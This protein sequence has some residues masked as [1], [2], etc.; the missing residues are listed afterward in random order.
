LEAI[1]KRYAQD[2][3]VTIQY[4]EVKSAQTLRNLHPECEVFIGA[5]GAHSLIRREIFGD[6]YSILKD[7]HHVV[8]LK[9]EVAGS[10]RSLDILTEHYRSI[11]LMPSSVFEYVGRER[12]SLTPI[13]LRFFVAKDVYD[14]IGD[15]SFKDPV[16][17]ENYQ[18]RLPPTLSE[19]INLY[20]TIRKELLGDDPMFSTM[21]LGKLTLSVY[22]SAS[23]SRSSN[24]ANWYLVGDAAMGV[25]F[26]RSLN[27]GLL[28]GSRLAQLLSHSSEAV[29][30]YNSYAS[31][32]LFI[33][34]ARARIKSAGVHLHAAFV[35]ASSVVPWQVNKWRR[36]E[37]EHYM[38]QLYEDE[39]SA[40]FDTPPGTAFL[41]KHP[42][43]D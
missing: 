6:E 9:Y 42:S 14:R 3:S 38:Q 2:L 28:C 33:E 40:E 21:K 37:V 18:Q 17:I 19:S 32:R 7:L 22:G 36:K 24:R 27:A 12:D 23:F 13:T 39:A 11:K 10:T 25:P 4:T 8:E 34:Q 15:V 20:L 31:R 41:K 16:T 5:D 43:S 26:F 30:D 29:R 35:R 1:L